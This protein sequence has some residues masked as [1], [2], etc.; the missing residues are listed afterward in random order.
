MPDQPASTNSDARLGQFRKSFLPRKEP[1]KAILVGA[2][3]SFM[4]CAFA[5]FNAI[6]RAMQ[7]P[8]E[9]VMGGRLRSD[10][11]LVNSIVSLVL[12]LMG[13]LLLG[14]LYAH[15]KA[16]VDLYVNGIVVFD[17][18]GETSLPWEDIWEVDK[19]PVYGGARRVINWNYTITCVNGKKVRFRG[20]EDLETLGK[21]VEKHAA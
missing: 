15:K 9:G 5:A 12:L 13:L 8:L 4:A 7:P 2:V 3:V 16:R 1:G 14:L 19:E 21:I 20:L 18:R 17:W 11:I 6:S 10:A